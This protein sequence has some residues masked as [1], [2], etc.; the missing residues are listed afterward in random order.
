MKIIHYLRR[1]IVLMT[2][3]KQDNEVNDRPHVRID[4]GDGSSHISDDIP[5]NAIY[6]R[7]SLLKLLQLAGCP[8]RVFHLAQVGRFEM[9]LDDAP[10]TSVTLRGHFPPI[11]W[12]GDTP[13]LSFLGQ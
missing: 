12:G 5:Q 1:A 11:F 10:P 6:L 4:I 7:R 9:R 2:V 3:M 8:V 13:L